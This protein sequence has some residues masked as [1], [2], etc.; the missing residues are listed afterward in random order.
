MTDFPQLAEWARDHAAAITAAVALAA[1]LTAVTI[2]RRGASA[3]D[4]GQAEEQPEPQAAEEADTESEKRRKFSA[5]TLAAVAAFIICTSVSLNTGYRFTGAPAPKGLGMTWEPERILACA[6]FESLIAMCVLGARERLAKHGTP[7]WYGTAVW[8]FAGLSAVP[9]WVEGGGLSASTVVRIIVGSFGSALAAH[10][11]LG[12]ELR[13]RTGDESQTAMAQIT[14]DLRERLMARL[15]LAHRSRSAEEIARDRALDKAVDLDDRYKRLPDDEKAKRKGQRIARRLA[16]WQ[17]RAELA[18]NEAQRDLYRARVAQRQCATKL[19][20]SDA[21]SP[22]NQPSTAQV[23]ARALDTLEGHARHM[24][25][26]ASD[27]E[28]AL[29]AQIGTPP[30]AHG[31][32]PVPG[33]RAETVPEDE[34]E[35]DEEP[36]DRIDPADEKHA[37]PPRAAAAHGGT[38]RV[39][40]ARVPQE[41]D[42]AEAEEPGAEA[43]PLRDL[44]SY[45]TKRAALEALYCHRIAPDDP[46]TT[47]AIAEEL[48]TEL[49]EAGIAL[50]RGAA[51]RYIGPLR[52]QQDDDQED[53]ADADSRE[54]VNA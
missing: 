17:D 20:I 2:K 7:G 30:A 48:L 43:E 41:S 37:E 28:A 11:A 29:R 53:Q 1:V 49:A 45:P 10:S 51:N 25:N 19:S 54:L 31:G 35:A 27:A 6:G 42:E 44:R 3:S 13:H 8:V 52:P 36:S 23:Q 22:W 9:A 47:N 18:T 40:T 38:P 16:V 39:I 24:E 34:P 46:R 50:D 21:E 14:R 26:L 5:G 15:G 12:L 33:P 32:T 4:A